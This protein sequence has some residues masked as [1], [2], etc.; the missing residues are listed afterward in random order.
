MFCYKTGIEIAAALPDDIDA[1]KAI[2]IARDSQIVCLEHLITTFRKTMFGRKSEKLD[3]DQFEFALEDIETAIAQ[4]EAG[5]ETADQVSNPEPRK[6]RT[7]NRGALP[8]HLPRIEEVIQPER[9]ACTCGGDLHVI[10]AQFR[11]IVTRRPKYGCRHCETGITQ[12]PAPEHIIPGGLPTASLV[13][14]CSG[15]QVC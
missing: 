2:I 14:A 1:L 9:Q 11:V 6:P 10:P 5:N 4:T 15:L 8:K 12:A 7:A 13:G 3:A